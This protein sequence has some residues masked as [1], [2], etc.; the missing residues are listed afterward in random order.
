MDDMVMILVVGSNNENDFVVVVKFSGKNFGRG[1]TVTCTVLVIH[2][3]KVDS[4]D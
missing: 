2:E 3:V 4:I 1:G